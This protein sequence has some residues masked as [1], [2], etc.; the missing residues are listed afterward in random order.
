[1]TE[2]RCGDARHPHNEAVSA[3]AQ[4]CGALTDPA[5]SAINKG[6][7]RAPPDDASKKEFLSC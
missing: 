4:G 7:G 2:S 5:T 1:M 6:V 3:S